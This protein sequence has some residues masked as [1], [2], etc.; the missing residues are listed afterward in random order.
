MHARVFMT[1][2]VPPL[3]R[4][5]RADV[6]SGMMQD[7]GRRYVRHFNYRWRRSRTL[8]EGPFKSCLVQDSDSLLQCDRYIGLNSVRAGMVA[9]P[10]EYHWSSY[11]ANG[12][13]VSS[14]LCTPHP[15]YRA[16][17]DSSL[18]L[19]NYRGLFSA[20]VEKELANEI[21]QVTDRG[22]ALGNSRF[23]DEMERLTG[24][25]FPPGRRG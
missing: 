12:L 10:A 18:R 19:P 23:I 8:W 21:R 5:D 13:G 16:L 17:G 6:V 9:D 22:P 20:H 1:N 11:Q 4:P 25:R 15:E 3:A 2:H 14:S 24:R 7:I